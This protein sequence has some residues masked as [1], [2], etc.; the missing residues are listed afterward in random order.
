[1]VGLSN[2]SDKAKKQRQI[3]I[4]NKEALKAFSDLFYKSKRGNEKQAKLY[5]EQVKKIGFPEFYNEDWHYTPLIKVLSKKYQLNINNLTKIT[6]EQLKKLSFSIDALQIV[7]FNGYFIPALSNDDFYPYQI[8]IMNKMVQPL[9]IPIINNEIFLFLTESLASQPILIK[10]ISNQ[11]EERPIYILNITSGS[12]NCDYVNLS[13][14]RYH[15][16]IGDNCKSKVIEHFVSIDKKP[17]LTGSRLTVN[18]GDNSHFNHIKLLTQNNKSNHFANNDILSKQNTKIKSSSIFISSALSRHHTN[19]KLNGVN[20]KLIINTLSLP[21]N[22]EII[23]TRTYIEHNERFC[24]SHQ[25]HKS[26][27]MD[28]SKSIFNGIIKVSPHALKTNSKMINKNLLLGKHAE[29]NAKPQLEIYA[30]DVKCS[31]SATVSRIDDEQLF[32][33]R[34]RGINLRYA[35]H[36]MLIA[37]SSE[38][39]EYLDS[40]DISY[41]IMNIIRQRL[42][43]I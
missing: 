8:Q 23:D 10:L 4:L 1:M 43:G 9:S 2:N 24:E 3:K 18:I 21:Q 36:I 37:F 6:S 15:L 32:Y 22:K 25:L 33:L 7:F 42:T 14:Y 35:K 34:S 29:V 39:L 13:H 28:E 11:N 5:W 41:N 30:D 26:I 38:V 17:H 16:E 40:K 31:H 27:T 12:N 20:S 19:V